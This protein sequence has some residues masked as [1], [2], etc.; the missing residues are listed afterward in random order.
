MNKE[1]RMNGLFDTA[2]SVFNIADSVIERAYPNNDKKERGRWGEQHIPNFGILR[3][4][5]ANAVAAE[6]RKETRHKQ[7]NK[8]KTAISWAIFTVS[9]VVS[10]VVCKE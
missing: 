10:F 9:F 6:R 7:T 5:I 3:M 1:K 4:S 8:N 2:D